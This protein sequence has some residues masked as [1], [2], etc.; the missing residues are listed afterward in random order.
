MEITFLSEN[1][2]FV[3]S[4]NKLKINETE[5]SYLVL[6]RAA[7]NLKTDENKRSCSVQKGFF[8]LFFLHFG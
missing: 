8:P 6:I 4:T 3:I 1:L 2:G 7:N 5:S